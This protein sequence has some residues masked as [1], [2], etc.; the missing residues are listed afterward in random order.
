[1][2]NFELLENKVAARNL[3]RDDHVMLA[4]QLWRVVSNFRVIGGAG[5]MLMLAY[6]THVE[7]QGYKFHPVPQS[8][9]RFEIFRQI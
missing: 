6:H 8:D 5:Q 7:P 9:Q 1:M 3:K 2:P 4:D